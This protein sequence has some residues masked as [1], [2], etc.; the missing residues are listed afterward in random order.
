MLVEE[1]VET[2]ADK[3]RRLVVEGDLSMTAI[4]KEV[5]CARSY[6]YQ[7]ARRGSHH[8]SQEILSELRAL[9]AAL[10]ELVAEL[11]ELNGKPRDIINLRLKSV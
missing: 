9:R 11:R 5:G 6:V 7:A 8:D 10:V 2:K 3:I 1:S 4:A